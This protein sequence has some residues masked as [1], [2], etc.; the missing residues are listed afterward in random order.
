MSRVRGVFAV[1]LSGLAVPAVG[2]TTF[3]EANSL[4]AAQLTAFT[5]ARNAEIAASVATV[6]AARVN[7]KIEATIAKAHRSPIRAYAECGD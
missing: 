1:V 7:A 4:A 6:N 5:Q 2:Q 3:S